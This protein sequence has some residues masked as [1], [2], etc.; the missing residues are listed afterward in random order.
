MF[1]A[2]ET[3]VSCLGRM[4]LPKGWSRITTPNTSRESPRDV[5]IARSLVEQRL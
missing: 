4:M 5:S 2:S 1:Y 3:G